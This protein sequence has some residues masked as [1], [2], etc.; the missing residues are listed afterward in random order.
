MSGGALVLVADS[1]RARL[2]S[3]KRGIP[4]LQEIDD[5]VNAEA[6][7]PERALASDRQGRG[8]NRQRGSRTALGSTNLQRNSA[9]KFALRVGRRLAAESNARR[10]ARL[11][12]FAEAEFLGLLRTALRSR[13][14]G[15][16][17][18]GFAKNLTRATPQRIREYL[19]KYMGRSA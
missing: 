8:F 17:V 11:F 13:R 9:Q 10:A 18:R 15:L 5:W 14:P 19:P 16:P 7:L 2:F 3:W 4:Q 1:A 12:V 6:R